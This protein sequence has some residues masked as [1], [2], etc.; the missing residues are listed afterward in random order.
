M[1]VKPTTRVGYRQSARP[2]RWRNQ[3]PREGSMY[4]GAGKFAR[5]R[6]TRPMR[7]AGQGLGTTTPGYLDAPH[8]VGYSSRSA[9]L[10][11]M[12]MFPDDWQD[13]FP[14]DWGPVAGYF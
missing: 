11:A 4:S 7:M 6:N 2:H 5:A 14:E 9:G 13:H 1:S 10:D 8:G 12:Q 3:L